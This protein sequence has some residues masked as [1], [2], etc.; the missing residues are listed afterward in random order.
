MEKDQVASSKGRG[1]RGKGEIK[2]MGQNAKR[3]KDPVHKARKSNREQ[4]VLGGREKKGQKKK[5]R[6]THGDGGE[7]EGGWGQ[8]AGNSKV[9]GGGYPD[10]SRKKGS[11]V[12]AGGKKGKWEGKEKTMTS[13]KS[14]CR[15]EGGE[16][17]KE[18]DGLGGEGSKGPGGDLEK[19]EK[20]FSLIRGPQRDYERQGNK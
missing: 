9:G 17:G 16:R 3:E 14:P 15:G 13:A 18:K 5:L 7:D 20:D 8:R 10:E 6:K 4:R 11:S 12:Y 19:P 2:K 1:E